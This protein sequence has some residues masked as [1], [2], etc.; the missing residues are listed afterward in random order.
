MS[1]SPGNEIFVNLLQ[2]MGFSN[3]RLPDRFKIMQIKSELERIGKR[4]AYLEQQ[5]NLLEG[6]EKPSN[7]Q[8]DGYGEQEEESYEPSDEE[9]D[10]YN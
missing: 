8:N 9:G 2:N 1:P 6:A 5:L 10:Y 3:A 7:E 4:K